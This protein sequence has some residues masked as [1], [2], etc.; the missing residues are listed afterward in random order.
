M[1]L[2]VMPQRF[3]CI[4]ALHIMKPQGQCQQKEAVSLQ[5][6]Q[7]H[8]FR[9]R[10]RRFVLPSCSMAHPQGDIPSDAVMKSDRPVKPANPVAPS[11]RALRAAVQIRWPGGDSRS[12]RP[13]SKSTVPVRR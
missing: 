6:T 8:P 13:G 2:Q 9:R 3:S 1:L 7:M 10:P 11:I 4:Q 12:P 5:A